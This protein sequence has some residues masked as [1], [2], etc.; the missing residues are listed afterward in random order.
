MTAQFFDWKI[1][2]QSNFYRPSFRIFKLFSASVRLKQIQITMVVPYEWRFWCHK[3]RYPEHC[4]TNSNCNFTSAMSIMMKKISFCYQLIRY[5]RDIF[6]W[7]YATL[8]FVAI[9]TVNPFYK[10]KNIA[11]Q[12]LTYNSKN[13]HWLNRKLDQERTMNG[14]GKPFRNKSAPKNWKNCKHQSEIAT[15]EQKTT[16]EKANFCSNTV[17]A[18]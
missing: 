15:C 9:P 16:S 13:F 10:N 17:F 3:K 12:V 8:L 1:F 7:T 5:L 6:S 14:L 2:I 11:G 4:K 18:L